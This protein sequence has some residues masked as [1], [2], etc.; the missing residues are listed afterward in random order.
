[1]EIYCVQIATVSRDGHSYI[2]NAAD[3]TK[4]HELTWKSKTQH[5]FRNCRWDAW[6]R[7][8]FL[9]NISLTAC[10]WTFK[11]DFFWIMIPVNNHI[12]YKESDRGG[13]WWRVDTVDIVRGLLSFGNACKF[14]HC[15]P[16][17]LCPLF[18]AI[19]LVSLDPF[20]FFFLPLHQ[21][22]VVSL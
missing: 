1:M 2:W 10:L 14:L 9:P 6:L 3:G 12:K 17:K 21:K 4:L 19:S 11:P 15:V 13:S 8:H 7:I 18:L 16:R 20:S 22:T 5:R